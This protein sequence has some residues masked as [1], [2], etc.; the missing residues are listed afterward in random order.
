MATGVQELKLAA[1]MQKW[2][3]ETQMTFGL[4]DAEH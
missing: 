3:Q 2:S 4:S 1:R